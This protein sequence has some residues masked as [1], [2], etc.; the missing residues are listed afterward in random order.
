MLPLRVLRSSLVALVVAAAGAVLVVGPASPAHA[1]GLLTPDVPMQT[2][3]DP[4]ATYREQ[5]SCNPTAQPGTAAL[6][7]MV[8]GYYGIGRDGGISR[9]CSIGGASEHKE[10]RAWDWMLDVNNPAENAA[11]QDFMLWLTGPDANGVQA[12]NAR[13]LGV[14]YLIRNRQIWQ[15]DH[16]SSGWMAYSGP[17]PH[18]DHI[19]I[20]LSWD[21]AE[22]R[23]SWWTGAAITQQDIGP[24]RVYSGEFAPA[25]SGPRYTACPPVWAT[26]SNF[27]S[28]ASLDLDGDGTADTV[29][30]EKYTGL[31]WFY[32]GDGRGQPVSRRVV[33]SGWQMHDAL[34]L[35]PDVT[36]DGRPDLY[37]REASTGQLWLYPGDGTGS[38]TAPT[39]VGFGWGMHDALLAAGDVT[40]DGIPDLWARQKSTGQLWLYPGSA[41]GVPTT[42]RLLGTGWNM[43]DEL[44]APGDVTGD[45]KADLWGREAA[46][47]VLWLYPGDGR[48][49]FPTRRAVGTGWSMHDV[50]TATADVS[51]DGVPDLYARQK[52]TGN[53]FAYPTGPGGVPA[54]SR[55]TGTGWNM[56]DV[57]L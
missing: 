12:G 32:P 22:K 5:N 25:Y 31:L 50:L 54:P 52:G 44:I 37:A 15:A 34:V 55:P 38:F 48:G 40:G 46:T 24:C 47:G 35:T 16:A 29:G 45:G 1:A 21:G 7:A 57:L 4:Y 49:G 8:L 19:H 17:N 27:A 56:H 14:M 41:G 26:P 10:G 11:A 18:T 51:G 9:D 28:S 42:P 2:A 43:H 36:G 39:S 30:R 33:G 20:S 6:R 23:T 53:R 3:P 13:R